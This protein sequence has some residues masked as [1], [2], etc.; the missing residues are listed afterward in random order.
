MTG[1]GRR[2]FPLVPRRPLVGT[3][4]GTQRSLRRGPGAEIAGS[5]PYQPGDRLSSIDWNA[6]ARLSA[7]RNSDEFIVR[8]TFAEDA[9]KVVVVCDLRPEMALYPADLP[10]FSK[11]DATRQAVEAITASALAARAELG[12]LDVARGVTTWLAPRST[13]RTRLVEQRLG[14]ERT[15]GTGDLALALAQ[16]ARRVTEVPAGT[17]VFVISDFLEPSE[18][19]Q[20]RPLLGR[21][22]DVVPVIVRDPLWEAS[23]PDVAG[24]L[25]PVADAA[26]GRR[27][28]VRL[29]SARTAE[30]RVANEARA[31]EVAQR[32]RGFAV[33]SVALGSPDPVAVD[34]AFGA[35][36]A[37][38]RA[39]RRWPGAL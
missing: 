29:S 19:E 37:R 30:R 25:L 7:F 20:L 28:G 18:L 24:V 16:L 21:R 17:F 33:D 38:R 5:R 36:A 14:A 35:W 13:S 4:Y 34:A 9:P 1:A 10:F 12:W 15:A 32:L 26:G 22:L 6:S 2:T 3:V 31:A 11:R 8:Q 27:V 39:V 23:F